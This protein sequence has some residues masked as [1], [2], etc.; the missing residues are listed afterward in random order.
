MTSAV[1]SSQPPA[2]PPLPPPSPAVS[3]PARLWTRAVNFK[4]FLL[5]KIVDFAKK[6]FQ[7]IKNIF[8]KIDEF[9][10][11]PPVES[12]PIA[13]ENCPVGIDQQGNTCFLAAACQALILTNPDLIE[14]LRQS[15]ALEEQQ[16]RAESKPLRPIR[17]F[18]R[19]YRRAQRGGRTCQRVN[20]LRTL[21]PQ[22]AGTG[23][24]SASEFFRDL[25]NHAV[26]NERLTTQGIIVPY[27]TWSEP[28][29]GGERTGEGVSHTCILTLY[30]NRPNIGMGE[31]LENWSQSV[32]ETPPRI[33]R[34]QLLGAP[35]LLYLEVTRAH[36]HL[37]DPIDINSLAT[38][39]MPTDPPT[40]YG[41]KSFVF[42]IGSPIRGH[43]V[44][45]TRVQGTDGR[46]YYT[47]TNDD[48]TPRAISEAEFLEKASTAAILVYEKEEPIAQIDQVDMH[49]P[50][51][52]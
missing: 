38:V 46:F 48:A 34:Q 23:Q 20:E 7:F 33:E 26:I 14:V 43:Y 3:L 44:A 28:V 42:H 15:S 52:Q 50:L 24:H 10:F 5:T 45:F 47:Y 39:T 1:G 12:L 25:L 9:L 31:L 4:N 37:R 18:I 41:L 17:R 13:Q 51:G 40:R 22:F 35:P 6:T 19:E 30:S 8:T 11:G 2:L 32:T 29:G 21:F 49:A 16:G 27:Q 36:D